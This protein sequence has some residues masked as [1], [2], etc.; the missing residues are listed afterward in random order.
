MH[1]IIL[2]GVRPLPAAPT[3]GGGSDDDGDMPNDGDA[4]DDDGGASDEAQPG[5]DG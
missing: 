2:V 4:N 1:M 3:E 5:S